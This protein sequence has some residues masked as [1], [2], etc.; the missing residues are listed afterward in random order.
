MKYVAR[1]SEVHRLAAHRQYVAGL[2]SS[3]PVRG[4]KRSTTTGSG[5]LTPEEFRQFRER[6][7]LKFP[8]AR[9]QQ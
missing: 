6:I 2:T 9:P 7:R 8:H 1:Q 4:I 5:D 3:L